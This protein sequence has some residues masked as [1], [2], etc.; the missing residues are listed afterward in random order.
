MHG[1]GTAPYSPCTREHR[2]P[3]PEQMDEYDSRSD[4]FQQVSVPETDGRTEGE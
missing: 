3:V 1:G 2:L 4:T